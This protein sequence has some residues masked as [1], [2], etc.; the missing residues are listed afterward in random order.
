M[1]LLIGMSTHQE[2]L[3]LIELLCYQAAERPASAGYRFL[4]D[5]ESQEEFLSFAD[6]DREAQRFASSLRRHTQPGDRALILC[7]PGLDYLVS[8][9]GCSYAKVIAVPAYPPHLNRKNQR[10]AGIVRDCQPAVAIAA[11]SLIARRDRIVAKTE[12]LRPLYWLS[13]E[14]ARSEPL[15]AD[16]LILPVPDDVAFLQY[17]SGTTRAPRGVMLTHRNLLENTRRIIE[18]FELRENDAPFFWLPPYHDMGMIGGLL[19]VLHSGSST[20]LIAPAAFIQK[21]L[22]WLQ[23]ITRYRSQISGGPNFAYDLCVRR[24]S[25]EDRKKLDLSSWELAFVGAEPVSPDT[26][27]RFA[28]AFEP[29]GFRRE[30]FYPCYGLAEATLMVTGGQRLQPIKTLAVQRN[31]FESDGRIVKASQD[32][33]A[34]VMVG[35]GRPIGG[36]DVRIVDPE[37]SKPAA[38]NC[39]G[40]I[41]VAGPSISQGYW[42]QE[43]SAAKFNGQLPGQEVRYLR[44]GDLGLLHEGELYVTGRMDDL[45]VVRGRNLFSTD[46]ERV[47]HEA[48]PALQPAAGA[49][50]AV[51]T[52]DTVDLV[53]VQELIRA[54]RG[55]DLEEVMAS[56]RQA[57]ADDFGVNLEA[58]VL[59]K[60]GGVPTTPS[61]KIQRMQCR[62][63]F[64]DKRLDVVAQWPVVEESPQTTARQRPVAET[65][66]ET[67]GTETTS[68][69][70][71]T[72]TAPAA[73]VAEVQAIRT[74]LVERIANHLNIPAERIDTS[75]SFSRYG[76]DSVTLVTFAG[77]LESRTNRTVSPTWLYDEPTIE[78]FVR[79]VADG[80]QVDDSQANAAEHQMPVYEPIAVIGMGCRFPYSNSPEDF[81]RLLRDGGN[82]VRPV[83]TDRWSW[84]PNDVSTHQAGLLDNID[85][86]DAEFFGIAPTEARWIDPQHRL[87]LEVA[88]ESLENAAC[89]IQPLKGSDVGVFVGVSNSEYAHVCRDSQEAIGPYFGS[90]NATAMAAHRLSYHFDFCGPSMAVDTACSSSLVAIHLATQSLQT[91]ECSMALAGGVNLLMRPELSEGLS[92]AKM[93]SPRG[94]CATFDAGADGYV[95]GEGCGLVVLKRLSDAIRDGD[96]VLA[97]IRASGINQDGSTNGITAPNQRM[98]QRLIRRTL[99]RTRCEPADITYVETHGTGTVLGDPIE[100][101][102]LKATLNVGSRVLPPCALGA[103]KSNIGHLE[104][105]AGIASFI[106]VV[107]ALQ[108]GEIPGNLH[109]KQINPHLDLDGTRFSIPTQRQAWNA[110]SPRTAAISG[111]GFGGTNTHMILQEA[112]S[113]EAPQASSTTERSSHLLT[114][115]ARSP[116]AL[117]DLALKYKERLAGDPDAPL[118]DICYSANRGRTD[119]PHRLA[120]V[121]SWP[122]DVCRAID[123]Y[124]DGRQGLPRTYTGKVGS[125]TPPRVAFLFSGQGSQYAGMGRQLYHTSPTFRHHFDECDRILHKKLGRS[126]V[127]MLYRDQNRD[128]VTQTVYAQPALFA[129]EYS[130]ASMLQGWGIEPN[131]VI[132]HSL[133][134]YV[135]ACL[136]DVF[137][138]ED[139]LALVTERAATD[140][141]GTRSRQDGLRIRL[142]G[143]RA[144][145]RG[146]LRGRS[147]DCRVQRARERRDF[148][149]AKRRHVRDRR[150]GGGRHPDESAGS[151]PRISFA[152]N[153]PGP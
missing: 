94:V 1:E 110:T 53:V 58:I 72:S 84:L 95:R 63:R 136:A 115:S 9:L 99:Q 33:V 146:P 108:H 24:I 97:V 41:W 48:H 51:E 82:G 28:K 147:G 47:V 81:W 92:Q 10:L 26:L 131:E 103:V 113:N 44:T 42:N 40:E 2:L 105:A 37:T 117:K 96:S 109:F 3:T 145:R 11:E 39:V 34:K 55:I 17:T 76:L 124:V 23:G 73:T 150:T 6:L 19:T 102:A 71:P 88:W 123:N 89:P 64:I 122:N 13:T 52:E 148:R 70:T 4:L 54:Y 68:T 57:V 14:A 45:M 59:V 129:L 62:Q 5:G 106:K 138:L 125:S 85:Q 31:A 25:A 21:P 135:A 153:G 128:D 144:A 69:S 140:A 36:H 120:M 15:D 50:F 104:A 100:V 77:D 49:T 126:L 32:D 116:A 65:S 142:S 30:A 22:R 107:L 101:N 43:S 149:F 114:L 78:D 16:R 61:G 56:I 83:P 111:F 98:Q 90:G 66:I 67:T 112:N 18:Y 79:R 137:S 119:F 29:C 35:C 127:S 87:L 141:T 75:Q 134:E 7:S 121:A 143:T 133:G 74:W 38:E 12:E 46:I 27:D 139:G 60:P 93:L 152:A 118:A 20:T 151:I 91:R 132:G 86:F 130:L 80:S 8:L